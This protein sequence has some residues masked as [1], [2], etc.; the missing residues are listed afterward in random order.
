MV[1]LGPGEEHRCCERY[2]SSFGVNG[3]STEHCDT[4]LDAKTD[5][6]KVS[7]VHSFFVDLPRI[8]PSSYH[9]H[10]CSDFMSSTA[11]LYVPIARPHIRL[12]D[13]LTSSYLDCLVRPLFGSNVLPLLR[14]PY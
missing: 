12:F 8:P 6:E 14:L 10:P 11:A 7:Y 9:R 4:G 3:P 1:P 13:C 5:L 2:A